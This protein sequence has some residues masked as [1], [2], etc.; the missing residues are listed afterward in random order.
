MPGTP[1][2]TP[3]APAGQEAGPGGIDPVPGPAAP[4]SYGL[5]PN[6]DTGNAD[7]GVFLAL[8]KLRRFCP[9]PPLSRV[10]HAGRQNL[11]GSEEAG[12]LR[13]RMVVHLRHRGGVVVETLL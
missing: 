5:C 4:S 11:Q 3:R 2:I 12:E 13:D 6:S 7:D 9:S 10:D 1:G 8:R